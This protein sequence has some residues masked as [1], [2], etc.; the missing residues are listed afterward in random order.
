MKKFSDIVLKCNA[1]KYLNNI[2]EKSVLVYSP[3]SANKINLFKN[4]N[5]DK[6]DF[7]STD[8]TK[9][10]VEKAEEYLNNNTEIE[11]VI[12]FGGGTAIDV[13]KYMGNKINKRIIAIPSMLST[14]VY[15]TDKV[16]MSTNGVRN[17]LDSRLPD[18]IIYDE[19]ILKLSTTENLFGFADVLTIYTASTDWKN[20]SE[21]G[22]DP[23]NNQI[24]KMDIDLL[25]NTTQYIL[26][27]PYKEIINGLYPMFNFIGM[28][29][30]IT[31]LYGSGRPVSGSEHIFAKSLDLKT[32]VPHGIAVAIGILIMSLFQNNYSTDIEECFEKLKI[33]NYTEKYNV[34]QK[35]IKETLFNLQPR[36]GRYTIVDSF[37]PK[38]KTINEKIDKILNKY[39]IDMGW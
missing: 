6:I 23:M 9:K 28:V 31:N 35:L 14:N 38:D 32:V 11:N 4:V 29:G 21:K 3:T 8:I 34:T 26:N 19:E 30:H 16:L 39:N 2:N 1:I 22:F 20:S 17:T 18:I 10:D 27:T 25:N 37:N 33:F 24:Y 36:V 7:L 5:N 13:A 15:S 12:G